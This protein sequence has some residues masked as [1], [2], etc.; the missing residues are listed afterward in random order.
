MNTIAILACC[1][2]KLNEMLFLRKYFLTQNIDTLF[3]DISL[4]PDVPE[5]ENRITREELIAASGRKWEELRETEKHEKMLLMIEG[6]KKTV[7]DLFQK[8]AFLSRNILT[9]AAIRSMMKKW[10]QRLPASLLHSSVRIFHASG[11]PETLMIRNL[12]ICVQTSCCS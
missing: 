11:I 12:P 8:Q 10:M 3:L 7:P 5:V 4:G 6:L 2:T 9:N 1:D